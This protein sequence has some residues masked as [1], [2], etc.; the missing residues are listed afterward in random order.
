MANEKLKVPEE[1]TT[2]YNEYMA[3]QELR[4]SYIKKPFAFK[5]AVRAANLA[6]KKRVRFWSEA[7]KLYPDLSDTVTD[8]EYIW[9]QEGVTK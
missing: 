6:R 2:I 8:G 1:L 3:A 5:R 7:M 9:K 4:D